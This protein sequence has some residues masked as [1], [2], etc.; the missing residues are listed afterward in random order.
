MD[1]MY[2]KYRK[3]LK[4]TIVKNGDNVVKTD[5]KVLP[6]KNNIESK[7]ENVLIDAV[8][9]KKNNDITNFFFNAVHKNYL[10]TRK[11]F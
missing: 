1:L 5:S 7:K 9:D 11:K 6:F 2:I 10:A 8:E 3:N 4:S